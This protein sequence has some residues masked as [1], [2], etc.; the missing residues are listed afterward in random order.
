MTDDL[1]FI[2]NELQVVQVELADS[3]AGLR[4]ELDRVT[5]SVSETENSLALCSDEKKSLRKTV[6][7]LKTEINGL[8]KQLESMA[9]NMK[10]DNVRIIGVPESVGECTL[11]VIAKMLMEVLKLSKLLL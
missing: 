1:N 8:Q 11:K 2:K 9:G 10:Q 7:K 4:A 6:M 5:L 3:T